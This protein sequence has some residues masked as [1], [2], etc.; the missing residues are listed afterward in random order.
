LLA[1][2]G[3]DFT[4]IMPTEEIFTLAD[5]HRADGT[6]AATFPLSYGGSLIEDFNVIFENGQ[7]TK[8]S[9]KRT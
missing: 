2:N 6:V 5:S 1:E 7:I 8:V 3:V 4:A 9:A